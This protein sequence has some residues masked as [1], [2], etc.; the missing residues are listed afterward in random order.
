MARYGV[1][2]VGALAVL[3][4]DSALAADMVVKAQPAA[5]PIATVGRWYIEA[6]LGFPFRKNYN[7]DIVAI[8]PG[9]YR[10]DSGF[11]GAFDVGYAF[12][13][14]WRAE[15]EATW[16]QGKNGNVVLGAA[17]LPHTG[18]TDV[19]T[20]NVNGFYTFIMHPM[21]Q[22]FVGAGI[23]IASYKVNNLG[24]VGGGF[25]I[26]D[27]QTT[28][29]LALHAGVDIP[30]SQRFALTGRYTLAHT[31]DMTFASVPAGNATTRKS[32]F[33]SVLSG[34]LRFYLN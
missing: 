16:T 20:F 18:K 30:I 19:Y 12:T 2:A 5:A 10:P 34:G 15:I 29:L 7:I 8:G 27:S 6:R 1:L 28:L 25:V 14:N 11:H 3:C 17:N 23:G 31:G 22:P 21:F 24:A 4:A 13:P 9:T 26:N 32:T 33:D